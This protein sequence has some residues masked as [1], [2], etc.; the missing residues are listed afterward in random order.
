VLL[1]RH[2]LA[3]LLD[4]RTHCVPSLCS[5]NSLAVGF[6]GRDFPLSRTIDPGRPTTDPTAQ[7]I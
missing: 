1:L 6:S 3:A 4:D 2:A 7:A 5:S